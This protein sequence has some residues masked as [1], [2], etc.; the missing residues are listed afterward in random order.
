MNLI[1]WRR[2]P[3]ERNEGLLPQPP[4]L[5]RL[6]EEIDDL[7][8]RFWRD[9][10]SLTTGHLLGEEQVGWGPRVNV[11][12]SEDEVTVE[13]ELP[14][15]DP[16]EV[17]IQISGGVLTISGQ[18]EEEHKDE[19]RSYHYAERRLG[20]FKRSITLP[21]SVDVD[22]VSAEFKNGLLKV[23]ASKRPEAKPKRIEVKTG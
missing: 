8:D 15:I 7:F 12:E 19:Q 11:A 17:D 5:T 13:A 22:T 23:T 14:G 21:S 6:R 3:E 16:K 20:R 1:P 10:W 9:P 2:K 18:H 4:S